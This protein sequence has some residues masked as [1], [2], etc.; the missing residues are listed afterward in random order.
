[1]K[2]LLCALRAP[3]EGPDVL[4]GALRAAVG[5][6]RGRAALPLGMRPLPF[7][8]GKGLPPPKGRRA[9]ARAR[10]RGSVL[11]VADCI[12]LAV[13]WARAAG[14]PSTFRESRWRPSASLAARAL[15]RA[16][17]VC[18]RSVSELAQV[19]ARCGKLLDFI[20]EVGG[21]R[22]VGPDLG[23]APG[24]EEG[25]LMGAAVH[26]ATATAVP[27]VAARQAVPAEGGAAAVDMEAFLTAEEAAA[28]AE[29][30][31]RPPPEPRPRGFFNAP[32]AEWRSFLRRCHRAG[33]LALV[34]AAL[35]VRGLQAGFFPVAKDE[36]DARREL[37]R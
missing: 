16:R 6:S 2:A 8:G 7:G 4:A 14:V 21:R 12:L 20:K 9:W 3:A 34:C 18:R 25:Y 5:L 36:E 29:P 22:V 15:G 30:P 33:M 35:V 28:F 24:R 32:M 31:S 11:Q 13:A 27:F 1:M 37:R 17:D 26:R 10:H 23:T 19:D